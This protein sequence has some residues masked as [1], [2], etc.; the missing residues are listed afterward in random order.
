MVLRRWNSERLVSF[1]NLLWHYFNNYMVLK[2][3]IKCHYQKHK[4]CAKSI[5]SY[6]LDAV[7]VNPDTSPAF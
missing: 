3:R 6:A 2:I 4:V 5:P 7:Q 1:L